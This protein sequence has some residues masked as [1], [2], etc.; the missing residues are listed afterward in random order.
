MSEPTKMIGVV[1]TYNAFECAPEDFDRMLEWVISR[2]K[3]A[4]EN[5]R[6]GPVIT[7][8][9]DHAGNEI[10]KSEATKAGLPSPALQQIVK[11]ETEVMAEEQQQYKKAI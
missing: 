10:G 2:M 8:V 9:Y 4:C 11:E 3:F 1:Q 5:S 6:R 7:I